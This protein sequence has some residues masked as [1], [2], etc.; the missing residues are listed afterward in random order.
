LKV[1]S[2]FFGTVLIVLVSV[3]LGIGLSYLGAPHLYGGESGSINPPP[4]AVV[5]MMAKGS[6]SN[7]AIGFLPTNITVV[8]G[9]NSTV[10]FYNNDIAV[11]TATSTVRAFDT[12]PVNAGQYVAVTFNQTG[13]YEYICQYHPWM[14]GLINVVRRA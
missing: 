14:I 2:A 1:T 12:G 3:G 5:V 13:V 9:V 7:Q 10:I 8:L 11:H 4:G 6:S